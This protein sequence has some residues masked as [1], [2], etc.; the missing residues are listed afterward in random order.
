MACEGI[1]KLLGPLVFQ[2]PI[3]GMMKHI[4]AKS[5]NLHEI[6]YMSRTI[7]NNHIPVIVLNIG[8]TSYYCRKKFY[9]IFTSRCSKFSM[10][11][12]KI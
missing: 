7:E 2:T 12:L 5:E 6:S 9:S 8:L 4:S 3:L 10:Q 1:K 11:F